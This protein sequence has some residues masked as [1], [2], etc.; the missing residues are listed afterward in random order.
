MNGLKFLGL[1]FFI[2]N[3]LINVTY[4]SRIDLSVSEAKNRSAREGKMIY[5]SFTASWCLPCQMMK[6]GAYNDQKVNFMLQNGMIPVLAEEENLRSIDWFKKY[7]IT[8]LPTTLVLDQNGNEIERLEGFKSVESIQSFLYK[9]AT[10][11]PE[12]SNLN[13]IPIVFKSKKRIPA[14]IILTRPN[15]IK[16]KKIESQSTITI[17]IKKI[18]K[19]GIGK[20]SSARSEPIFYPTVYGIQ[21]N[22][23]NSIYDATEYQEYINKVFAQEAIILTSDDEKVFKVIFTCDSLDEAKEQIKNFKDAETSCFIRVL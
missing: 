12:G 17:P 15:V 7:N 13:N 16:K 3:S 1:V 4:A 21:L 14:R 19:K 6:E 18:P 10:K 5:V 22:S 8:S 20:P 2:C 11:K 9:Y 23:F